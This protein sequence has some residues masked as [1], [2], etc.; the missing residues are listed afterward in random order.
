MIYKTYKPKFCQILN[1]G[2]ICFYTILNIRLPYVQLE[3][4]QY[5]NFYQQGKYNLKFETILVQKSLGLFETIL[6]LFLGKLVP[7]DLYS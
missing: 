7:T 3:K 2:F 6:V 4:Y 1:T 5:P